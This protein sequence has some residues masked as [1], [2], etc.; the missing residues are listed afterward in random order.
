MCP[1]SSTPPLSKTISNQW[2]DYLNSR[3]DVSEMPFWPEVDDI[4]AWKKTQTEWMES[5]EEKYTLAVSRFNPEIHSQHI[6]QVPV[7]SITPND[8]QNNSKVIVYIHGGAFVIESARTS[9]CLSVPLAHHSGLRVVSVD[10]TLAPH[11]HWNIITDQVITVIT[12]LLEQGHSLSDIAVA[13]DSAGGAIAAGCILKMRDNGMGMPAATLLFSPWSDLTETGDTYHTL[14]HA[15]PFYL[16]ERH[17]IKGAQAYA[18]QTPLTH[19][20]V[21][22]VYGDYSQGFPPTLIQGGTRELFLSNF[23]RHYQALDT[24]G[25]TVKLDLYDG[26]PHVFQCILSDAPESLCAFGKISDFLR[27]HLFQSP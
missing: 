2:H 5:R 22:P 9:T 8:W 23:V 10:Y 25:Q 19:P 1:S 13:G 15:E 27:T 3:G 14:K 6:N 26:L 24:A 4:E 20:Y 11:A 12:G 21:S 18:G 16:Y 7:L 17:L